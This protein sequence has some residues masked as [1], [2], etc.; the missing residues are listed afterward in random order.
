[1]VVGTSEGECF[2]ELSRY[3]K[4]DATDEKLFAFSIATGSICNHLCI[5]QEVVQSV[6]VH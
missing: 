5:V 2:R 6:Q 4:S 1:M 3:L